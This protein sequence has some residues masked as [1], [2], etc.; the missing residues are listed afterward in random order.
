MSGAALTCGAA[1]SPRAINDAQQWPFEISRLGAVGAQIIGVDLAQP[2]SAELFASLYGAFLAHQVLLFRDQDI[3][4]ARQ[5]DFAKHFGEVQIHVMNQYHAGGYPQLYTL[6]NLDA[7]GNPSGQHPD[8]GTLAWHTDGSWKQR[9]GQATIM[10]SDEVP[11]EGGETHFCDMYA[12]WATLSPARQQQLL[13]LRAIHNLDFSRTRRHRVDLMT[14]QQKR[15]TPPVSQPVVRRH[16]D[17]H[18]I[19]LYLGD[20]AETIEGM[21]YDEGREL[22]EAVNAAAIHASRIYEHRWRAG[23]LIVWDNRALLHRATEYDAATVR[24]VMRRCTVI[25]EQPIAAQEL[26]APKTT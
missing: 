8:R 18:R 16:P 13:P 15:E 10:Y 22:V 2:V 11:A 14:E 7:D 19:A 12:A 20:H 6:S 24:R 21:R 9:S 23:D 17:T 3:P 26:P 25:G 4:P 5:V 1:T